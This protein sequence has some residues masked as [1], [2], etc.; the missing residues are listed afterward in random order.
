MTFK[1]MQFAAILFGLEKAIKRTAKK[2]PA[3]KDRLAEKNFTAQ[4]KI[5]DD[6]AGRYFTFDRGK[7]SSRRGLHPNPDIC[8]MFKD[9]ELAVK[10]LMP[11]RDHLAMINAMKNFQI[12]LQGPDDLT[13]WFMETLNQILT[14]G[15]E[16]GID[17]GSG[18]KRY[19]SNTNGGPVFAYVKDNKIIR[20]TPI[21]FDDSDAD[22]WTITA[23][24]KKFTPPR[25][26]TVNPYTLAWKSMV[27]SRDR[28]LYP[29]KRVD[30][31]PHGERNCQNRG[32]SGYE[33]ISWDEALDIV[34]GQIRRVKKEYGPGAILNGSGSHHTWG[35]L[36]YWLSSRLRFFNTIGFTP[37]VHNPDSWEG[38]YWGA[39]HHWGHSSRLGAPETY[40]TVEDCLKH[41]EM[42]VF[43]S[44]DPE[45]TSGVYGAYEGTIR[46]QWLKEL[47]IKMVHIDP[48][49]NHTA[50][51]MGGKWLAPRPATGNALALAIAYVWIT[52]ALYDRQYV[53]SRTVGFD[54][55]KD[56]I[57]GK[58][59]GIPKTPEWQENE[60]NIA[61]KDVRALAREWGS[62]KTYLA[63]GGL[64]GF[65][66]ACRCATGNEWA[67]SMVCLM[68]MQ[69]LGKP[70]VNM[71]CLQ[72]GTPLDTKFFFPGYAE[73]GLSGDIQGTA[74]A[75]N[76]YQRMPQLPTVNSVYQRVPRLKIP[77]AI[78]D[79]HCEGY[80]TDPK[81]IEGQF[82]KFGYPTPGHSPVK[83][84]YKYGGSHFGTMTET[85]RYARAY[86][87]ENLE[88][89]V[90]QSIWFEG[91]AKFAD[92]L[93]PACTSF[94]RWD[95]S[96]F[97]NCGGY[98][99]HSFTQCNHRVAVLQ[100]KCIEPLGES[101]SDY[102]IFWD[103]TK[104]LGLAAPF[105]EGMSELDWCKRLFDATDLPD[106]ISWKDFL[107]KGYFV[108]PP[109]PENLRDPVSFRWFAEDRPKD[110]PELAPLPADY[111]E[112]FGRGLQTQ[113]GKLEFECSS[114]K[115][116]D[117]HDPERPPISKYI[118][119][120]E[121][122]HTTAL[123]EKYPLQLISPH[124]RFSFHTMGDGK[125]SIV[126]DVKDHRVLIDGYYYWIVRINSK[127]AAHRG[128]GHNDLVKVFNDR[129]AVVCAAQVTERIP[130]GSVHS[131]ESA[132]DYDPVGEPGESPDRGGCINIL[133]PSRTIIKKSHSIACNSCLVQIEKWDQ[134]GA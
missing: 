54:K 55:W 32:I 51:L 76:M 123:Y 125:D 8:M 70:G 16:Y 46:R 75:V 6:S 11:P 68:A 29:M 80:P 15:M 43:W 118:P 72:Q 126:N 12:G 110:T 109:P 3:F 74:M 77:E 19:T 90:N 1:Q 83:M 64:Q 2:Y 17:A 36:G 7:V 85:N 10:L 30:F 88:F 47:G 121:G 100:H 102:Q 104:R 92:V 131:Y 105:S 27:Y 50:A 22:P 61:A 132:A 89:V 124:P 48:F 96:E 65:G 18:V 122:H 94:E 23:R 5:V 97:A 113:S 93:L 99:Q 91:E 127:D 103:L 45:S 108:I 62:K 133:T 39:M 106:H 24:G 98:I 63:A 112:Q 130:T 60:S 119:A 21:E 52:E 129:G 59:D 116:F 41:S 31:D 87:S 33:R 67:R 95:I 25:K 69:G 40:G 14:S 4:I 78:L 28:L 26:T 84:Y 82:L 58:E 9:A 57:L 20:I 44:S 73:G 120:W 56:Y 114:L 128:I 86:R 81:T 111:T 71:G 37:V 79:G 66:S 53:A 101:K 107:K 117:P 35:H 134:K 115:R 13:M 34:A 49:Y 38:W 42:V